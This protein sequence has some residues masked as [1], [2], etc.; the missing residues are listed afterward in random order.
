MKR[1]AQRQM[2]TQVQQGGKGRYP[3]ARPPLNAPTDLVRRL[4]ENFPRPRSF[5]FGLRSLTATRFRHDWERD[6]L[7]RC[8]SPDL[9]CKRARCI[10]LY[11]FCSQ[12]PRRSIFV[13]G[14]PKAQKLTRTHAKLFNAFSRPCAK[15]V[16]IWYHRA[17]RFWARYI[18]LLYGYKR[19]II[20]LI[21]LYL[22]TVCA[23]G[24]I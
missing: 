16:G 12:C 24:I 4:P 8:S 10:Q 2:R 11:L 22:N 1:G 17:P 21:V 23:Y 18:I 7:F 9:F 14:C 6:I 13:A 19:S 3:Q 5:L 15:C 20:L